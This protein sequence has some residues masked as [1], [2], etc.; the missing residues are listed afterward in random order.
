MNLF[1]LFELT[2]KQVG[3]MISSWGLNLFVLFEH[4]T[5]GY[6]GYQVLEDWIYLY[7][8]NK[9]FLVW[10]DRSFLRIEF[11]CIIWTLY[12]KGL[13]SWSSWG[14]NLFVLFERI[15]SHSPTP[16]CSWG[17]NLFVLFELSDGVHERNSVLED[18]IYLYYLN[19][20][21]NLCIP[22][23]VLENWI[24][25]YYLNSCVWCRKRGAFLRIEFICIIWTMTADGSITPR[26]WGLNL[27][28]LFEQRLCEDDANLS[29]WG[30]NL[31]VLFDFI[32]LVLY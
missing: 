19:F 25:L 29:S 31:F 13:N 24:Y 17:L 23:C 26:S 27:F 20:R 12:E 15:R 4:K 22:T 28:V 5:H 32:Y 21:F 8:L 10:W 7:Y 30:L 18:W 2:N 14:L 3:R 16:N 11:I 6:E 9:T 1:V